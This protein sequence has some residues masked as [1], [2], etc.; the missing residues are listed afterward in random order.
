M[1]LTHWAVLV[2]ERS[3]SVAPR[4]SRPDPV[5]VTAAP[6]RTL[7]T[8][9]ALLK[10]ARTDARPPATSD[11]MFVTAPRKFVMLMSLTRAMPGLA[12]VRVHALSAI[13]TARQLSS[14]FATKNGGELVA[15]A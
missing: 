1:R 14:A 15:G 8:Y 7:A 2:M 3:P 4:I 10:P 9:T 11:V 13:V 12:A 5:V 6:K